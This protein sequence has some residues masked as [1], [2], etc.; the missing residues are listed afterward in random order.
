MAGA[1]ANQ[2]DPLDAA[3]MTKAMDDYRTERIQAA[4]L[5]KVGI[6]DQ[7]TSANAFGDARHGV[8]EGGQM[9]A[10]DT[11][12]SDVSANFPGEIALTRTDGRYVDVRGQTARTAGRRVCVAY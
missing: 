11:E 5:A 8:V 2:Q 4:T 9:P 6:G 7:A 10:S 1:K 3:G 12:I